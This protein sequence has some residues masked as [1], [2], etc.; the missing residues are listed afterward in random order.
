MIQ[1]M[2]HAQHG[3]THAYSQEQ[4]SELEKAGWEKEIVIK[5]EPVKGK[6]G[7]KPKNPQ[8]GEKNGNSPNSHNK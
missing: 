1:R 7:R 5:Q 3:F 6:P 4:V 2:Q 8:L